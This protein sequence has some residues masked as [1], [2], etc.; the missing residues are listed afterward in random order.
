[1]PAMTNEEANALDELLTQTTPRLTDTPGVFARQHALLG[2]LDALA[3][4]YILTQ[5]Q[6]AHKTPSEIIGEM[7]RERMSTVK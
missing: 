3:A 7:V 1:M 4:N 5:A 6:A 2:A